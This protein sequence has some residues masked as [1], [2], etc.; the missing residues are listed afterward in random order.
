MGTIQQ[1]F[2]DWNGEPLNGVSYKLR[3]SDGDA[4]TVDMDL[5]GSCYSMW[6]GYLKVRRDALAAAWK[7][8]PKTI[9]PI[10]LS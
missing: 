8:D 3:L 6:L 5:C 7:L 1:K 10:I 4:Y 2:C 9:E